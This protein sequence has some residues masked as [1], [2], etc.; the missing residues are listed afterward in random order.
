MR[1]KG[2]KREKTRVVVFQLLLDFFVPTKSRVGAVPMRAAVRA[3]RLRA[4]VELIYDTSDSED[5]DDPRRD[6]YG[7]MKRRGS[8]QPNARQDPEAEGQDKW[9]HKWHPKERCWGSSISAL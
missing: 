8:W 3:E 2:N 4:I 9:R 5:D 7:N 6:R 1:E